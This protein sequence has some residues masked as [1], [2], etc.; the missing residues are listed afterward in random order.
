MKDFISNLESS[1]FT[2]F[3]DYN[4]KSKEAYQPTLI[5][6]DKKK[7]LKVLTYLIKNFL[8]CDEFRWK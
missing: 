7:Q 6:N 8:E 2:G 1:I 4:K 5:L 3:I